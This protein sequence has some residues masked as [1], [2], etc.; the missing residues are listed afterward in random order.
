LRRL[1]REPLLHFLLLGGLLFI[2]YG[3]LSRPEGS[4]SGSIVVTQGRI[5]NMA[6]LFE[7]TWQRPP[8]REELEGLIDAYVR[9][10]VVY[11]EGVALG[12]DRDDV[13]VRQRVKQKMEFVAEDSSIPAEPSEDELQEFLAAHASA[14]AIPPRTTFHQ[15]FIDPLRHRTDL[16]A[17]LQRLSVELRDVPSVEV[18]ETLGDPTMLPPRFDGSSPS[19]VARTFG[20]EFATKLAELPEN[21][22]QGPVASGFGLHFVWVSERTDERTPTLAEVRDSVKREL[23]HARRGEWNEEYY[24]SLRAKYVVTIE[25]PEAPRG[26]S[27]VLAGAK[28]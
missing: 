12:L 28:Q 6:L 11:R 3:L 2:A 5:E 15:V 1:L 27:E 18:A 17:A 7:R 4:L 10:E 16:D 21:S 13:V 20:Q 26:S 25:P 23:D 24:R 19:D 14:F 9:E 22:W 8:T